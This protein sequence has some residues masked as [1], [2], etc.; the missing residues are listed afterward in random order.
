[1]TNLCQKGLTSDRELWEG[2]GGLWLNIKEVGF[3]GRWGGAFSQFSGY[4]F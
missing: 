3:D 4:K 1:M 2:G